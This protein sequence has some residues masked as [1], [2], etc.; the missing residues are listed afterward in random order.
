MIS[1]VALGA[2]LAASPGSVLFFHWA[3]QTHNAAI[4]YHNRNASQGMSMDR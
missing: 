4:N 1:I 3:N 2:L